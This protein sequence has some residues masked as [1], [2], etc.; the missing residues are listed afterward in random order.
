MGELQ[1]RASLCEAGRWLWQKNLVG[2]IE[3][4][5]SCRLDA[6]TLLC[7]PSGKHKGQL[8]PED[9]VKVDLR[10][11]T[12]GEGKPSSELNLHL[13]IYEGRPDCQAIVHAHPP[14]ATSFALAHETLPDNLLPEAAIILGSVAMVPF[15]MPGSTATGDAIR[16]YL[17]DHKTFLLANHGAVTLGASLF[18][19]FARMETL[20]R[21]M[22]VYLTSTRLLD[23]ARAL[24]Q[25]AFDHLLSVGLNA[26][27]GF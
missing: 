9:I 23:G 14:T 22:H 5:L 17:A 6:K 18:E 10:G 27:L 12:L 24:P 13:A 4:N 3:G 11:A 16:P 15:A 20:E 8:R 1:L 26:K 21:V 2:A 19:A 25:E 7:S